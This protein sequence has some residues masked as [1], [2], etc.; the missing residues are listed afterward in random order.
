M[1]LVGTAGCIRR[2]LSDDDRDIAE[3]VI[4]S[5]QQLIPGTAF[6]L[7]RMRVRAA[8]HSCVVSHRRPLRVGC[9]DRRLAAHTQCQVR[10]A[11]AAVIALG[12]TTYA[13]ACL[14]DIPQALRTDWCLEC[15]RAES[16][17]FEGDPCAT[18]LTPAAL[19]CRRRSAR[20]ACQRRS[21]AG[22][23]IDVGQIAFPERCADE[24]RTCEARA[25]EIHSM[26]GQ[27]AHLSTREIGTGEVRLV[28]AGFLEPD[29]REIGALE[30]RVERSAFVRSA[31][32]RSTPWSC[33][34]G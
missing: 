19:T 34:P 21:V 18:Y 17:F 7:G 3:P 29:T 1:R 25:L 20:R 15:G 16:M 26:Q 32:R 11:N 10:H 23:E 2:I 13:A 28:E 24:L 4:C 33:A 30:V 31:S 12:A 14:R 8:D 6:E 27:V 5:I 22:T 9:G